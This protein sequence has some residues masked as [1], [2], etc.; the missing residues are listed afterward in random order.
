MERDDPFYAPL[1]RDLDLWDQMIGVRWDF[2]SNVALKFEVGVGRGESR[3]SSGDV[4]RNTV[5][6]AGLQ[7]SWVF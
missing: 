2:L 1:D 7:L 4:R 3:S 6:L 5:V